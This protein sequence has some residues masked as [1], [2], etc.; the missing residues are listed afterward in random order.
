MSKLDLQT[1]LLVRDIA[2]SDLSLAQPVADVS[3]ASVSDDEDALLLEQRMFL[4]EHAAT[5]PPERASRFVVPA[6]VRL[7]STDVVVPKA[8]VPR[9]LQVRVPISIL[10]VLVPAS[11]GDPA[12]RPKAR[13]PAE[14]GEREADALDAGAWITILPLEH[15]FYLNAGEGLASTIRRETLRLI[16]ARE[17]GQR[18]VLGLFPV[19]DDAELTPVD[20]SIG[21]AD[22]GPRGRAASL[23]K[24]I[25]EHEKRKQA[26]A[27]LESVARPLHRA[28]AGA[29]DSGRP[30]LFRD[31]ELG[32]VDA[33]L[34]GK[35]RLSLLVVGEPREGKSALFRAYWERRAAEAHVEPIV[36]ATSGAEIIAGM[37][38]LGQWQERVRR[39]MDAAET[40][41]AI[42]YLDDLG[43]LF[44]ARGLEGIDLA[45]AMKPWIEEGRVRLV[46]ELSADRVDFV[47]ARNQGFFANLQ[48]VR[49][50]AIDAKATKEILVARARFDAAR[51]PS[52]PT[53]GARAIE[54]VVDLAERYFPYQRFP[55]KAIGLYEDLV[56]ARAAS[57]ER[58]G[59]REISDR[60]VFEA[61]SLRTGVP[62]A[63]LNEDRALRV[64]D[65]ERA[66]GRRVLGQRE[67]VRRVAET[68]AVVKARIEAPDKPLGTFLFAGPTG[69]GK[70]ELARGLATWL[71]G[72]EQRLVRLDMS[73][74]ADPEAA[75][76][77]FR[78]TD[79]GDGV[80]TRKVREQPFAVVLLDEI[81]KAHG[82]V[83]D[84]LLQVLGEGRLTDARG[85]TAS[86]RNTIVVLTTNLGAEHRSTG[87]GFEGARSAESDQY[88]AAAARAFR[89]E[90]VNRL[91]RIIGFSSLTP[92]ES[93]A[94][95]GL[96]VERI[97]GRR[98]L[99]DLGI[100]L[101]VSEDA[102]RW[103]ERE[104]FSAAYGAR[105]LR[106]H[107]ERYVSAPIARLVGEHGA[108]ARGGRLEVGLAGPSAHA[109]AVPAGHAV[110]AELSL[111]PFALRLLRRTRAAAAR[112]LRG[113]T[114]VSTVR[115]EM[116]EALALHP[117]Q[118]A[119]ERL[120][121]LAAQLNADAEARHKRRG[122][123]EKGAGSASFANVGKLTAEHRRYEALVAALD[124]AYR[125]ACRLE[126]SAMIG[127]F[128]GERLDAQ[129]EEAVEV[130]A[131]L[132]RV[133]ART[134]V[135]DEPRRD[136]MY[137][138]LHELDDARALNLYLLPLLEHAGDLKW[139]VETHL[140]AS[141]REARADWPAE[142]RFGPP[143]DAPWI[144]D[145]LLGREGGGATSAVVSVRGDLAGIFLALEG[146]VHRFESAG[147]DRRTARL[148]VERLA[149]RPRLATASWT[150]ERIAV[151][152][153]AE[154]EKRKAEKPVRLHDGTN[155]RLEICQRAL[156]LDI[157]L[158]DYWARFED[159]AVEHLLLGE[160][161]TR[162]GRGSW[163]G[164]SVS[165]SV[166]RDFPDVL[167]LVRA[168][169]TIDALRA[170]RA[171]TGVGL[172][173]ARDA[174]TAMRVALAA[175][176]E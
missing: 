123:S 98:G 152:D 24:A 11:E 149:R 147:P 140:P 146:G 162:F 103:L 22:E 117:I 167:E 120:R 12:R 97:A 5:I 134:L 116:Q 48:R 99:A 164:E 3:L 52:R 176:D 38:G 82:A 139:H 54:T 32:L 158:E 74:Y 119:R 78:G 35:T 29:R 83:F 60:E 126:E 49:L 26:V 110:V 90:L 115:R 10:S 101:D 168:G 77:L 53:M 143:R 69:V 100:E 118:S 109:P 14:E 93:S 65:V 135:A 25:A 80:L 142:R 148:Y 9:A 137:L 8:D 17:G 121:T 113:M 105:S 85:R 129:A 58:E 88:A 36:Y 127:L 20:L 79:R 136:A 66:L 153:G 45:G 94:I 18:D 84:I 170:Y 156:T 87:I 141:S 56:N 81:E 163:L 132:R 130:R 41:D 171:H 72:S 92:G 131:R 124:Y 33:A 55:G 37:S 39:V 44:A 76:R 89:P 47:E 70:T 43:D 15:T 150:H 67:A 86:F 154:R 7:V 114:G 13:A 161:D 175:E 4:A 61:M 71:F 133:L 64:E 95:V 96:V 46:G 59:A 34:G 155:A 122:R 16:A 128:D 27:I 172:P 30:Y 28:W 62:L 73:E 31:R 144:A 174:I 111:G 125:D 75:T 1:L 57:A 160:R 108:V 23:R 50:G 63:L 107:A 106:R 104:G 51:E 157:R 42:L 159:V 173:E 91:D 138:A 151:L 6:G 166:T 2:G 68:L 19:G 112:D 169:K 40:L 102:R 145:R 21:R 165:E